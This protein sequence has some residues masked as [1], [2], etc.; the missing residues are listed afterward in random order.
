MRRSYNVWGLMLALACAVGCGPKAPSAQPASGSVTI[1][2]KPAQGV[3]LVFFAD[4]PPAP[5]L[6]V[7]TPRAYTD[8][9]G[10]YS[11]STYTGGDGLPAGEYRISASWM[12]ERPENADPESFQSVDRL[13]GKY[14]DPDQSGLRATIVS[15]TNEIPPI[16]LRQR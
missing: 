4:E 13:D 8:A 6:F 5:E 1:D 16:E 10:A 11:V 14:G 12:T 2:G 7:P 15:G 3:E 9:E